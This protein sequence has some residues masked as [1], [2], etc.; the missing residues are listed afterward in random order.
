MGDWIKIG[1]VSTFEEKQ[2]II[3]HFEYETAV[4]W[5]IDGEFHAIEDRC[6]HDDGPLAD[7][8]IEGCA[9]SCPRHG[10][11]FDIRTGKALTMPAVENVNAYSL[12]IEDDVLWIQSPDEAW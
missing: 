2:P 7:G 1:L 10:A 5:C 9:I 12:K 3:H 8:K 4:I 11:K 6:S